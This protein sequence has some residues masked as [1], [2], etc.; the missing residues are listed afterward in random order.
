MIVHEFGKN[1]CPHRC[2]PGE[3]QLG[4]ERLDDDYPHAPVLVDVYQVAFSRTTR[5]EET[6]YHVGAGASLTREQA[7]VNIDW[8]KQNIRK[9]ERHAR[10]AHEWPGL[11]QG[12]RRAER[13]SHQ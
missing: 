7:S 1:R 8:L 10:M 4:G 13:R 9:A 12:I 5:R 2:H 11:I 6:Q 3:A